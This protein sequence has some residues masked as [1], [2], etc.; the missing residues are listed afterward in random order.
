VCRR[1]R[2]L[3]LVIAT[4]LLAP[5][6]TRGPDEEAEADGE[7]TEATSPDAAAM[8]TAVATPGH[9]PGCDADPADTGARAINERMDVTSDGVDRWYSQFVPTAYDGVPTPLVVDLHGY[10][11]GSAGQVAMSDLGTVAEAEGIVVATPQGSGGMTYWNAVPHADLPD[12]VGFV[13]DVIDDVGRRLCID[14]NRVYVQG[15]SN[16]AFLTS[17]VACRLSD[18]VAAVAAVGG[19]LLPRDCSPSRAVPVLA[20]HGTDDRYVSFAGGPNASLADLTWDEESTAAFDG[21]PWA[22]VTTTAAGW[23]EVHECRPE[24]TRT[25]VG[26]A[27]ELIEYTGCTDD[28]A[29]QLYVV[30]GGGH[31]WPGSAFSVASEAIL[32]ATTDEIDATEL[33]WSFFSEHPRP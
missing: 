24:P 28:S 22:D 32:G 30:D 14:P 25:A 27:V 11:S 20:I 7:V 3:A 5:S 18:R 31:S 23:A 6:C 8:N 29:V 16:G 26:D 17:L 2:A 21:L 1:R 13:S 12:D 15:F 4:A 19:L 10:L 9:S 33:I